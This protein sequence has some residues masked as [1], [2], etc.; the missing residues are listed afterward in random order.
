MEGRRKHGAVK[1]HTVHHCF[2]HRSRLSHNCAQKFPLV[3]STSRSCNF[4]LLLL[5]LLLRLGLLSHLS[6]DMWRVHRWLCFSTF[7]IF[8][9]CKLSRQCCPQGSLHSSRCPCDGHVYFPYALNT[10]IRNHVKVMKL[11]LHTS[12]YAFP[13]CQPV[14]SAALTC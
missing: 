6:C 4:L 13:N 7:I 1:K 5:L 10:K 8:C 9:V 11:Y 3:I 12:L 2:L 14:V